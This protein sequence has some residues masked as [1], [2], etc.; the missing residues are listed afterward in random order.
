MIAI[1]NIYNH[2]PVVYAQKTEKVFHK[3]AYIYISMMILSLYGAAVSVHFYP[4]PYL[5]GA[6]VQSVVKRGQDLSRDTRARARRARE[7]AI[8]VPVRWVPGTGN[9]EM[10]NGKWETEMVGNGKR[11][12]ELTRRKDFAVLTALLLLVA[13]AVATGRSTIVTVSGRELFEQQ[14]LFQI[15]Q[16]NSPHLFSSSS[17]H[18]WGQL[19]IFYSR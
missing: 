17:L 13:L 15:E 19:L 11:G 12:R 6:H 7:H 18:L 1:T 5:V 2:L 10:G 16:P 14:Q 3:S 9:G 8:Q 4:K